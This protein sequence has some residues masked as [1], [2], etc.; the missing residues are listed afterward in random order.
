MGWDVIQRSLVVTDCDDADRQQKSMQSAALALCQPNRTNDRTRE[1]RSFLTQY[2]TQAYCYIYSDDTATVLLP[3]QYSLNHTK[4]SE[5]R[6][7]RTM[8]PCYSSLRLTIAQDDNVR[9]LWACKYRC[10]VA[11]D[12]AMCS[13]TEDRTHAYALF[14][15]SRILLVL[16]SD[17]DLKLLFLT[18]L[19]LFK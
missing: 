13:A 7:T 10:H 3:S 1:R 11:A 14:S 6:E 4:H 19:C 8:L 2:H 5:N 15:K 18:D 16:A 17:C 9:A 12:A